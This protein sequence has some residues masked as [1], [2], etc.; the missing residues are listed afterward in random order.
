[1]SVVS[2]DSTG[3]MHA[4]KKDVRTASSDLVDKA[5]I[6]NAITQLEERMQ[7]KLIELVNQV[8]ASP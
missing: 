7:Q 6:D 8:L 4:V 2:A 1:M 5:Y 3:D